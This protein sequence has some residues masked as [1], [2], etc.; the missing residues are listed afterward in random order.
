MKKT[1]SY[2]TYEEV[3]EF[4]KTLNIKTQK[5]WLDY[6]K[7]GQ[8]PS[9]IPIHVYHVY[10]DKGWKGWSDFFGDSKKNLSFE[11]TK[12]IVGQLNIKTTREYLKYFRNGG[13][14]LGIPQNPKQTFQNEG[15]DGWENFLN[16]EDSIG[17]KHFMLFE[18]A[19]EFARS[20]NLKGMKEWKEWSKSGKRPEN[21]P[22]CPE[23]TY[24]V[25]GWKGWVDFL[26]KNEKILAYEELEALI[27]NLGINSKREYVDLFKS[28]KLPQGAQLCPDVFYKGKGWKSW[29][30]FLGKG[31]TSKTGN[32]KF[33][34][35]YEEAKN[36]VQSIGITSYHEWQKYS[37]SKD[38]HKDIP[39]YPH[40][41]YKGNGWK[42]WSDFLGKKESGYKKFKTFEEA[43]EF[44]RSMNFESSLEWRIFSKSGQKP[45]DIPSNPHVIYRENGWISWSDFLNTSSKRIRTKSADS[46]IKS[47]EEAKKI[48]QSL[49][50]KNSIEWQRI[51]KSGQKPDGIPSNPG[52]YYKDK[53]WK[54]FKDFFGRTDGYKDFLSFEE[55]REY[56]KSL[57][58]KS[59]SEWTEYSKS[60]Q[61]ANNIPVAPSQ[62]YKG[63]GWTNWNDFL[64]TKKIDFLSI[65]EAREFARNLKLK[66][67]KEWQEWSKSGKRNKNIPNSPDSVYKNKGWKG[68]DDFLG[69]KND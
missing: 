46:N 67:P 66:S 20:L 51:C 63:N 16:K 2:R 31:T 41:T 12:E 15:W 37:K 27:Q 11:E 17:Y 45:K 58:L 9:D 14:K 62:K 34:L 35:G 50:I 8:R 26:G 13:K 18:E 30:D 1:M 32:G 6:C 42:N 54:G 40:K 28:D 69:N 23:Q 53:G 24:K 4:I 61:K 59:Q 39:K 55:A 48:V 43:R 64:G 25:H 36:F 60:G 22:A 65:E 3:K 56:V 10:K 7:S 38:S 29:W 21:I 57:N 52:M 33:F 47:F 49:N 5:E 68:W 44:V 19:R